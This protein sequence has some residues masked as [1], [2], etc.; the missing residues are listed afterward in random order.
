LG[1][2]RRSIGALRAVST[3]KARGRPKLF[4][5]TAFERKSRGRRR[6]RSRSRDLR[7]PKK[8]TPRIQ[9]IAGLEGCINQ[10]EDVD[11]EGDI[12][13]VTYVGT[14]GSFSSSLPQ[15]SL[16]SFTEKRRWGEAPARP[17]LR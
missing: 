2:Q 12:T 6:S 7:S 13:N 10:E 9:R 15:V 1:A 4:V 11:T 16:V 3:R 14:G 8:I 5:L 17:G